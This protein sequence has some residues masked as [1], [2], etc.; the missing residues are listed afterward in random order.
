MIDFSDF[1]NALVGQGGQSLTEGKEIM[2]LTG[3]RWFHGDG[4]NGRDR[5]ST[6]RISE[7][8]SL[9]EVKGKDP[10]GVRRAMTRWSH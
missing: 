5:G 10:G 9:T 8:M 4:K 2:R 7:K 1:V 6:Q 3:G